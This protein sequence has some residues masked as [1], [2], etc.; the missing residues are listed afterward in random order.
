MLLSDKIKICNERL[1]DLKSQRSLIK[2]ELALY[3]D[4]TGEGEY[5]NP[6]LLKQYWDINKKIGAVFKEIQYLSGNGANDIIN[7]EETT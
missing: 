7:E 1:N 4:P 2:Q 6:D 3:E 5:T